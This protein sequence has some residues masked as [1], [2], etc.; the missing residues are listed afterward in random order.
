MSAADVVK[1]EAHLFAVVS[2][3]RFLQMEGLGG[4]V[5]VFIYPYDPEDA[6]QV[7]ESKKRVKTKLSQK[8]IEVAE[9]NL[10]ELTIELLTERGALNDLFEMEP[11]LSKDELREGL[12]SM[13]DP[14]S[15]IAP[16][17]EAKLAEQSFD[18]F[19]LTG[20]GEV[21]PFIRSHNVLNNL[22]SVARGRPMVVFFPGSYEQL[23]ALGST[24][25]LFGTIPDDNYYRAKNIREQ[26]A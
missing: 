26:E 12:R 7:A 15:D 25:R 1:W 6:L 13:I 11:S 3:Q 4:E 19:F 8:G 22:E 18:I 23:P 24:L 9:V 5:P 16:A 21:F 17:I 10:Y 14:E 20:I 2:S